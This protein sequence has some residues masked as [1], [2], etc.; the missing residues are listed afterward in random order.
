MAAAGAVGV[1]EAGVDV[2]VAGGSVFVVV[3]GVVEA[4]GLA[5]VDEFA[6]MVGAVADHAPNDAAVGD[7]VAGPPGV[8]FVQ[9]AGGGDLL[10]EIF[11]GSV[12]GGQGFGFAARL[13]R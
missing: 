5:E 11:V 12:Q 1:V 2:L 7:D 4:L 13:L 3:V 9:F 6:Q 10:L 8:G